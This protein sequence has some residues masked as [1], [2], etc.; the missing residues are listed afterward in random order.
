MKNKKLTFFLKKFL[1]MMQKSV[2]W[3]ALKGSKMEWT[4]VLEKTAST[5]SEVI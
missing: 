3:G 1:T 4:R 5:D 2:P